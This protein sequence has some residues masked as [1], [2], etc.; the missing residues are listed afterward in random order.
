MNYK[1]MAV[2][3]VIILSI[4]LLVSYVFQPNYSIPE[5]TKHIE[6]MDDGSCVITEEITMDIKSSVNGVY[7]DLPVDGSKKVT[8]IS[9][10]TPGYYNRYEEGGNT[11][12]TRIR[13]WLYNDKENTQKVSNQKVPVIFKY[14]YVDALKI[15][16]D[17][18]DFQ[19]MS[20]GDQWDSKVS[21]LKTF[22]KIPGENSRTEVWNNP[23][24]F[25]KESKWNNNGELETIA[26]DIPAHTSFEQRIL[27]PR[28]YFKSTANAHVIHDNAKSIIEEDQKKYADSI[29]HENIIYKII[30]IIIALDLIVPTIIYYLYGREVKTDYNAEYE[31]DVPTNLKPLEAH[32][33]FY[34]DVGGVYGQAFNSVILDL[35]NNKYF[36]I[37]ASTDDDTII[38]VNNKDTSN[39]EE[40]ETDIINYLDSFKDS[41]GN[42]SLAG[43]A[44]NETYDHYHEFKTNWLEKANKSMPDSLLEQFFDDKGVKI[45]NKAILMLFG[46][47]VLI[48]IIAFILL[49]PILDWGQYWHFLGFVALPVIMYIIIPKTTMGRWNK[50]GKET[51]E[52]WENFIKYIK[53]DSLINEKPPE[54]VQVWGR[55][56]VYA[57][58]FGQAKQASDTLQ[59]YI[60]ASKLSNDEI[61]SNNIVYFTSCGGYDNFTSSIETIVATSYSDSGSYG[62][63]GSGGFGGGGGGTF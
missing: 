18:A 53:D 26:E 36:K 1:T 43:I 61:I 2:V 25:V 33:L 16:D 58:A 49:M 14:T 59:K 32:Y 29:F 4:F 3:I 17:V 38:R 57:A 27:M 54:S 37:V 21:K 9:V 62:S 41:D 22:I 47:S 60:K 10:E 28:N 15:Y 19:Y 55:Y 46:I 45:F 44:D 39:L 56:L 12:T 51:S 50:E 52:K 8:N 34:V 23:N 13:V 24:T 40:Y 35:I 30:M 20:W 63:S 7:R 11:S 31:Y 48:T 6:I 42:I 5:A